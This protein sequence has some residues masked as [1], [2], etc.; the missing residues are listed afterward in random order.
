MNNL[1]VKINDLNNEITNLVLKR[2]TIYPKEIDY[3]FYFLEDLSY[4]KFED[5]D[6]MVLEMFEEK[7][8]FKNDLNMLLIK[9]YVFFI[10]IVHDKYAKR[11]YFKTFL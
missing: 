4:K 2:N 3:T 10:T 11:V 7:I 5:I 6:I 9:K 8:Y 1:L